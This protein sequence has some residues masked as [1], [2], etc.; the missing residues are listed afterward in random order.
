M[1]LHEMTPFYTSIFTISLDSGVDLES[2]ARE[3]ESSGKV[4]PVA[5]NSG[6]FQ[7]IKHNY[8]TNK[9]IQPFIDRINTLMKKLYKEYGLYKEPTLIDYWFNINRKYNFNWS[10]DHP[11]C[12]FSA[13]Y[14]IKHSEDT[15]H[16]TF[17]RPDPLAAWLNPINL[18]ER[19][20][21]SLKLHPKTNMLVIFPSYL[22]HRVE[23]NITDEDRISMAFNFR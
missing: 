14:Y 2:I 23:Q 9:N 12:F 16:L 4:K 21:P 18:N 7:S 17:D 20:A 19:N 3:L 15:G 10:H 11:H 6:G 5:S 8:D 13:V 22:K 1:N